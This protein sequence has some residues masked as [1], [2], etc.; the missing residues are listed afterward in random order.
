[1]IRSFSLILFSAGL[2]AAS[3]ADA[4]KVTG[5]VTAD[6]QPLAG[7]LVTA[8]AGNGIAVS[9][10]TD[11]S[12]QF[13]I[14][15]PF[16][17]PFKLRAR[18]PGFADVNEKAGDGDRVTLAASRSS[19]PLVLAPSSELLSLLP[20]GPEKSRFI[21]NCAGCHEIAH[22]RIWKDG[23][24]RDKAKW[25][26]AITLMKAI[27][28]YALI[29]PAIGT[30]QYAAWL[31]TNLSPER[32]ASLHLE[33]KVDPAAAR[34]VTITEYPV[35]EATELPHDVGI[36]PDGRIWVTAFWTN[37]MW[38]MDPKTGKI[39]RYDVRK[40]DGPTTQVRALAFDKKGTL[41]IVLGG[42]KSVVR[43]DTKTRKFRDYPIGIYAHDIVLDSKGNAWLNDYF[44]KPERVAKLNPATGKVT[45]YPLPSANLSD[46]DG[47]PLPYG[48]QIDA[49]DRL[50]ATQMAGN[51]LVQY[52][53]NTGKSKM[54]LMPEP[55]SGPR[56]LSIGLNGEIWIPEF[57][58][59]YL[60]RFDPE[61][62]S[63]ER[64]NLGNSAI[65]PYAV[66][67]DQRNGGIWITGSLS[68][69]MLYFDPKTH[70]VENYP[71]P[72][73]PAYMRHLVVDG[74]T[75]AMWTTYSSLPTAIPKIVR[76]DRRD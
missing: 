9:V 1:M 26:E 62:G 27:D 71:L 51:T 68:S 44:S 47:K 74:K 15:H 67:V 56:R 30:E 70:A 55:L 28:A 33:S 17:G 69:S 11:G 29:A 65:G 48:L 35:P 7:A 53:T 61:K 37:Q 59:G 13:S 57:D 22:G 52:D 45:Y 10:Y 12:G 54:Y 19:D 8:E 31:A 3:A 25:A 38:A 24:V 66:T 39:D 64:F 36:G 34:R 46:N 18:S 73:E 41:W 72:T 58:T 2:L 49:K 60:T 63:F 43:L 16:A 40:G 75:G 76:L 23:K 14:D 50:W 32:L 42:S 6:G 4:G 21:L 5:G 20:D